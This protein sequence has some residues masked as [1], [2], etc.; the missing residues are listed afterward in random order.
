MPAR[1]HDRLPYEYASDN[2]WPDGALVGP[3]HAHQARDFVLNLRAATADLSVREAARAAGLAHTTLRKILLGL[4][5][6]D[7]LSVSRLEQAFGP[8]WP[9]LHSGDRYAG[10]RCAMCGMDDPRVLRTVHVAAAAERSSTQ[11]VNGMLLCANCHL[12][13]D[14]A[15][16]ASSSSSTDRTTGWPPAWQH[17]FITMN[18]TSKQLVSS[19]RS[20]SSAADAVAAAGE[21]I[22]RELAALSP[23]ERAQKATEVIAALRQTVA[24]TSAL[25]VAAVGQLRDEGMSLRAVAEALGVTLNA[26][27]QIENERLDRPRWSGRSPR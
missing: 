25:R 3:P 2:D 22:Q 16:S 6:P 17:P 27:Y 18:T 8:L 26:V 24:E 10:E 20:A 21:A 12:L 13:A 11:A 15:R 9:Q 14:W 19:G 5:W 23:L 4:V 7:S 1:P